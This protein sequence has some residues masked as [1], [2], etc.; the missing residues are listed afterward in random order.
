MPFS[1]AQAFAPK[2]TATNKIDQHNN[3][4]MLWP[5]GW[6]ATAQVN[7]TNE[8]GRNFKI[9][10]VQVLDKCE[11]SCTFERTIRKEVYPKKI[12]D[13]DLYKIPWYE[14]DVNYSPVVT[15]VNGTVT[16]S[17]KMSDGPGS[18]YEWFNPNKNND[19]LLRI[20]YRKTFLTWLVV[21]D[22]DS[23]A[24]TFED[25]LC[26]FKSIAAAS[27]AVDVTKPVGQRVGVVSGSTT[28]TSVELINP[29]MNPPGS[30]WSD[31]VANSAYTYEWKDIN[32]V[33]STNVPVGPVQTHVDFEDLRKKV[34][35][36]LKKKGKEKKFLF[37]KRK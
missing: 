18:P 9:G 29:P 23:G 13:G 4:L 5:L 1:L 6:M 12:R 24:Q 8:A 17:A 16:M 21:V 33:T 7:V 14:E 27:L 15:G 35:Q 26:E 28:N 3:Y 32:K 31:P 19:P 22:T 30:V 36:G 25:V 34:E 11:V 10:F 37:F 20:S 2:I